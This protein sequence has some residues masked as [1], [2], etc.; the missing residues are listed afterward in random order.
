MFL[1]RQCLAC[2][3]NN[4]LHSTNL[5]ELR[6]G[7]YLFMEALA[8]PHEAHSTWRSDKNLFRIRCRRRNGWNTQQKPLNIISTY[9]AAGIAP[10][11]CADEACPLFVDCRTH[12]RSDWPSQTPQG[13]SVSIINSRQRII[14]C[15]QI[16]CSKVFL[17]ASKCH[18]FLPAC[19]RVGTI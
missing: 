17:P 7:N 2:V 13:T 16:S 15:S 9:W 8:L 1:R 6:N 18:D 10:R 11:F 19:M 3:S 14:N 12:C 4:V 5:N